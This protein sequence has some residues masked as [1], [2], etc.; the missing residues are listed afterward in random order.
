MKCSIE[1]FELEDT[2]QPAE[3]F[4]DELYR[5]YTKLVGKLRYLAYQ[6]QLYGHQLGGGYV[7]NAIVMRI[8]GRYELSIVICWRVSFLVLIEIE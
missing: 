5:I 2:T 8:C 1:Y 4:E 6:M 3:I 7:E